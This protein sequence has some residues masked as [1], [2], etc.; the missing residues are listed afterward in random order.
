MK[1]QLGC[2][3]KSRPDWTNLDVRHLP[4][5]DIVHDLNDSLPFKDETVDEIL[6]EDILEHFPLA[7]TE[8]IFNDWIRVLKRGG[9]I[10]ILVPNL[11]KHIELYTAG[12]VTLER[13]SQ[14]IYGGQDY[15]EN[16]HFRSFNPRSVSELFKRYGLKV[17]SLFTPGRG[18]RAKGKKL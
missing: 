2:G 1:L 10:E 17:V 15:A 6:A 8:R 18:I 5:V 13:M 16:F 12:K 3:T 11:D 7:A 14:M 4:G 9:E